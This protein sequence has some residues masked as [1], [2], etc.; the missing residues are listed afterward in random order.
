GNYRSRPSVLALANALLADGAVQSGSTGPKRLRAVLEGGVLPELSVHADDRAEASAVARWL[1]RHAFDGR[2]WRSPAVLYRTNAQ[3]AVL[4]A[5]LTAAR[6]PYRVRG[7][8]T[9]LR[10]AEVARVL[11]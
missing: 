4:E 10:R 8:Q 2:G 11:R 6:I 3:S 1:R 5:A 9:F 7:D